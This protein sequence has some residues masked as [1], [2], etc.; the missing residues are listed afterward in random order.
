MALAFVSQNLGASD[1]PTLES[2]LTPECLEKLREELQTWTDD[3]RSDMAVAREDI[4]FEWIA[5]A[6][7][8]DDGTTYVLYS[9]MSHPNWGSAQ[10]TMA[11]NKA[12]VNEFLKSELMKVPFDI[13]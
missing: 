8:K 6:S 2:H 7:M 10:A 1:L 9:A 13:F 11:A 5:R 3:Q 4:F 12:L